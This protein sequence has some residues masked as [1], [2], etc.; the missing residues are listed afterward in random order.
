MAGLLLY[1]PISQEMHVFQL[2]TIID[3]E[4]EEEG[5]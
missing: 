2:N 3:G 1:D 5:K 4:N